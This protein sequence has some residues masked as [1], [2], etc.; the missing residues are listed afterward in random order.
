[1]GIRAILCKS[2]ETNRE[3]YHIFLPVILKILVK[4]FRGKVQFRKDMLSCDSSYLVLV[5]FFFLTMFCQGYFLLPVTQR[6]SKLDLASNS[7][8]HCPK[9]SVPVSFFIILRKLDLTFH[10]NC[11]LRKNKK[12]ISKCCILNFLPSM[13]SV[14]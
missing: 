9:K 5:C 2:N 1:M 10:A 11:L 7:E 12:N 3:I 8:G 6:I 13:L 14:H 4:M